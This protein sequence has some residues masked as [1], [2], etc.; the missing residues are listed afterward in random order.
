MDNANEVI[1]GG[2]DASKVNKGL[3]E[4]E[5]VEVGYYCPECG[6]RVYQWEAVVNEGYFAVCILCD[7]DYYKSELVKGE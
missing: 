2:G 5:E 4:P 3:S 1:K 7:V 6:E